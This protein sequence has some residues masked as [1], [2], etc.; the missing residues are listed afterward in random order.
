MIWLA[1][2]L[3]PAVYSKTVDIPSAVRGESKWKTILRVPYFNNVGCQGAG[4][5]KRS[6]GISHLHDDNCVERD[7]L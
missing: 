6:K 1:Q 4:Q 2:H 5:Q 7:G 3:L